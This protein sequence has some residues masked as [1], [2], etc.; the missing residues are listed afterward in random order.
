MIAVAPA[1]EP[2]AIYDLQKLWTFLRKK[3]ENKMKKKLIYDVPII[4]RIK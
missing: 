3:T 2:Y 4:V 1:A